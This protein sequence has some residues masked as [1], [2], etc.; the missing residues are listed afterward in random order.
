MDDSILVKNPDLVLIDSLIRSAI[1][2]TPTVAELINFNFEYDPRARKLFI[3]F[4]ARMNNGD[5][6]E[7]GTHQELLEL[8]GTYE[9]LYNSQFAEG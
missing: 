3:D 5:I 7:Q 8:K 1:L 6:V 4:V 9:K 2:T